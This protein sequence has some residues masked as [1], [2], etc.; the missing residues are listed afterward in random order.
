VVRARGPTAPR[1]AAAAVQHQRRPR[2]SGAARPARRAHGRGRRGAFAHRRRLRGE[3]CGD[4]RG[5]V[6][7]RPPP[8]SL[9]YKVDTSRPSLRTNWTR[10][11]PFPHRY[12][13]GR[14]LLLVSAD[15]GAEW[16]CVDPQAWFV[17]ESERKRAE[18]EAVARAKASAAAVGPAPAPDRQPLGTFPKPSFALFR[19]LRSHFSK[20]GLLTRAAQ[21]AKAA[22]SAAATTR[23]MRRADEELHALMRDDSQEVASPAALRVMRH[24]VRDAA[25]SL[26]TRGGTR[27]VRLVRGRGGGGLR[28]ARDPPRPASPAPPL[29]PPRP[30]FGAFGVDIV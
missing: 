4:R 25:C 24:G 12:G 10:L 7:V 1:G 19:N 26:S 29:H 23:G 30:A 13:K 3:G 6:P 28:V 21:A 2:V 11:V 27:L 15:S 22:A 20:P 18:K 5:A 17:H 14:G 16:A 8:P 9:P